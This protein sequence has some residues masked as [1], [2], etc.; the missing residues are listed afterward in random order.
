MGTGLGI[1]NGN[2]LGCMGEPS[3]L[4][5]L[6]SLWSLLGLPAGFSSTISTWPSLCSEDIPNYINLR[7]KTSN[8]NER[9]FQLKS[10][11]NPGPRLCISDYVNT[12]A[13]LSSI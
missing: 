7:A 5:K 6:F 13:S 4:D 9:F 1:L 8:R 11:Q 3:G 12:N 2:F 10:R